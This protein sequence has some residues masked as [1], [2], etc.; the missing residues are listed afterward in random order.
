MSIYLDSIG[1]LICFLFRIPVSPA[2]KRNSPTKSDN[3]VLTINWCWAWARFVRISSGNWSSCMSK[4]LK[5]N[6]LSTVTTGV[7]CRSRYRGET[8]TMGNTCHNRGVLRRWLATNKNIQTERL[9]YTIPSKI[10]HL[11][12]QWTNSLTMVVNTSIHSQWCTR[13]LIL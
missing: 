11:A 7:E 8:I 12:K 4:V 9:G 2:I 10:L 5:F 1:A 6:L 13:P 3:L